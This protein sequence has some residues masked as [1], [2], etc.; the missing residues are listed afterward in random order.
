MMRWAAI[1]VAILW[2]GQA[3]ALDAPKGEVILT[4]DGAIA[5][6]N[7]N[8][9]AAFDLALLDGLPQHEFTTVNA[10]VS[11]PT[12]FSGVLVKDLARAVGATGDTIRVQALNDYRVDIPLADA[13]LVPVL[14]VTRV[15]GQTLPVRAKGPT[16]IVYRLDDRPDLRGPD[17]DAR[18]PWQIERIT[19]R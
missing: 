15:D 3:I 5:Q 12:R 4:V 10:F 7:S 14:L 9:G 11:K 16:W 18:M 19:F 6:R 2:S 1:L 17:T 8:A 13:D